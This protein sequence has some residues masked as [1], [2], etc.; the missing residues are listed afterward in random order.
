MKRLCLLISL[1]SPVLVLAY[2]LE[3]SKSNLASEFATCSAF[4]LLISQ[5]H[6]KLKNDSRFEAAVRQAFELPVELSNY[7]VTN[8]RAE[9]D[10]KQMLQEMKYNYSNAAI[11]I[12]KYGEHCRDLLENTKVRLQY[13]LQKED[14]QKESEEQRHNHSQKQT[15]P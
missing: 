3:L 9:L 10:T 1:L 15:K 5:G 12:N 8:A 11:I 4:Y 2:D 6:E 14:T 7:D 13:W